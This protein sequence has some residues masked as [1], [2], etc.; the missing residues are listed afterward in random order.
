MNDLLAEAM[1][2]TEDSMRIVRYQEADRLML[3]QAPVIVLYYDR[4]LRILQ[5]GITGLTSNPMN[6]LFLKKVK[7]N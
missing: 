4:S 3:K 7:M 1:T 2:F 6:H 5:K